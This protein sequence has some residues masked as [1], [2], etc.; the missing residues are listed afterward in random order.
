MFMYSYCY[1]CSVLDIVFHCVVL[2]I[3][4]VYHTCILYYCHRVSIQ[5]HLTNISYHNISYIMPYHIIFHIKYH[6][7]R[8]HNDCPIIVTRKI[9]YDKLYLTTIRKEMGAVR[10]DYCQPFT[11]RAS[12]FVRPLAKM[13]C[14]A[15]AEEG[16][17]FLKLLFEDSRPEMRSAMQT[18]FCWQFLCCN[19]A[20]T[21]ITQHFNTYLGQCMNYIH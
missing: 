1:V 10:C 15:A 7:C 20:A 18:E 21:I 4:C 12:S 8:C 9:V 16:N 2:C 14:G 13:R 3:V 17:W 6:T 19:M 11:I 5:L